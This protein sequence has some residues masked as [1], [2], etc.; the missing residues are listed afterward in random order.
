MSSLAV[1]APAARLEILA[2]TGPVIAEPSLFF[3]IGT[4]MVSRFGLCGKSPC[5]PLLSRMCPAAIAS[6]NGNGFSGE[7]PRLGTSYQRTPLAVL[8]LRG[9]SRVNVAE[10]STLPRE[11]R[12]P[13]SMS[14]D[15]GI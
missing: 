15:D 13:S 7:L 5:H 12:G 9:T 11:F 2:R 1:F 4:M 10:Y 14:F 6:G 8:R 3:A